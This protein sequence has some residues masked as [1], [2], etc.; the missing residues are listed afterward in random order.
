MFD[1]AGNTASQMSSITEHT[2]FLS[3]DILIPLG[4][5]RPVSTTVPVVSL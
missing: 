4:M 5:M 3:L 2:Y 1:I